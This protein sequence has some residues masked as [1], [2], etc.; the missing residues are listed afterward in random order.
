MNFTRG[1]LHLWIVVSVL[2]IGG[3][4]L[5]ELPKWQ[6]GFRLWGT[7]P[8]TMADLGDCRN[9]D[10]SVEKMLLGY[11]AAARADQKSP[12]ELTAN[13]VGPPLGLL[14]LG[15]IIAWIARGF[16]RARSK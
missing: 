2:W 8:L 9:T 14:T 10:C 6:Q 16:R 15:F 3:V 4:G 7:K 1:F 11:D 13:L 5:V 12:L